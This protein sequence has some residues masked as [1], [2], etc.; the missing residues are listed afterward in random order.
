[1]SANISFVVVPENNG[2]CV[3][4]TG[5][6]LFSVAA[7]QP[8]SPPILW[9]EIGL[10]AAVAKKTGAVLRRAGGES[11][12]RVFMDDDLVVRGLESGRASAP[13]CVCVRACA[14]C[15]SGADRGASPTAG[16]P[17]SDRGPRRR[18]RAW[19]GR[20]CSC[21]NRCTSRAAAPRR[22]LL[23]GWR[24]PCGSPRGRPQPRRGRSRRRARALAAR[25]RVPGAPWQRCARRTR[26]C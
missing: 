8:S 22:P 2:V 9:K 23:G 19:G 26:G 24:A 25:R 21:R 17:R 4:Q 11:A 10:T 5:T 6:P 13:R 16:R 18:S 15:T 14:R 1:M 7:E 3:N 12:R 20:R